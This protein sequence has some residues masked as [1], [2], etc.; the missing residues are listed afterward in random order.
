MT[1]TKAKNVL[2]KLDKP[3]AEIAEK[4]FTF[5]PGADEVKR[6]FS[7]LKENCEIGQT[8]FFII[9]C[10]QEEF[11]FSFFLFKEDSGFVNYFDRFPSFKERYCCDISPN[12]SIKIYNHQMAKILLT[13]MRFE[14]EQS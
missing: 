7:F 2:F 12:G 5:C 4:N 13:E 14:D 8:I 9:C 1:K 10:N 6:I 11:N 3:S